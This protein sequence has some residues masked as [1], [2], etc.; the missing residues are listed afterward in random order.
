MDDGRL[1]RSGNGAP[2]VGARRSRGR[3]RD[4]AGAAPAPGDRRAAGRGLLLI[5][6]ADRAG[7]DRVASFL[8]RHGI[9]VAQRFDGWSAVQAIGELDPALVLMNIDLPDINA[10]AVTKHVLSQGIDP[11]IILMSDKDEWLEIAERSRLNFFRVLSKPLPL[12]RLA[13]FL[14]QCLAPSDPVTA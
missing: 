6:D 4:D 3:R 5:V 8:S 12:R 9:S 14:R 2:S 1:G 10:I 13:E 7:N 11:Q